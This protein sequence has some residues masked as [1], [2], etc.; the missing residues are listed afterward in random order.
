MV[1]RKRWRL[2]ASDQCLSEQDLITTANTLRRPMRSDFPV[3]GL[4]PAAPRRDA[5]DAITL[6]DLFERLARRSHAL[7]RELRQRGL[8]QLQVLLVGLP[9]GL[10]VEQAGQ[11][12][13]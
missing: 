4:P 8:D 11:Q 12:P 2:A 9:L 7:E 13:L 6:H 5:P 1:D 10:D 3:C